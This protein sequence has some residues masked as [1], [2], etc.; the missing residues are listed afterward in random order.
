M[1][2]KTLKI[3]VHALLFVIAVAV[4]FLGLGV[5]LQFNPNLG[6]LLWIAAVAIAGLNVLWMFRSRAKA[7]Q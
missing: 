4:F 2:T 3:A 6:T 1:P 5:G 7:G